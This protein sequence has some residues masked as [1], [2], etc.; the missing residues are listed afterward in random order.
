MQTRNRDRWDWLSR[1]TLLRAEWTR[2]GQGKVLLKGSLRPTDRLGHGDCIRKKTRRNLLSKPWPRHHPIG[3]MVWAWF[4]T[5]IVDPRVVPVRNETRTCDL[6]IWQMFEPRS[7]GERR[8]V[9]EKT[10]SP[11][12]RRA[13]IASRRRLQNICS[14]KTMSS[15]RQVATSMSRAFPTRR[16][17]SPFSHVQMQVHIASAQRRLCHADGVFRSIS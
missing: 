4:I 17:P 13:G 12:N 7:V 9:Q 8:F 16:V 10:F 5:A 6:A 1:R 11:Q 14:G 3:M 15:F 2:S